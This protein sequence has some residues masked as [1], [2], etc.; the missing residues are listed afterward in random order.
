MAPN[1]SMKSKKSNWVRVRVLAKTLAIY[2]M[3]LCIILFAEHSQEV[4]R[5]RNCCPDIS[6][7]Y[8]IADVIS[9]Y[10]LLTVLFTISVAL[11]CGD[12]MGRAYLVIPFMAL[13]VMDFIL[14]ALVLCAI[15][16]ELP[17]YLRNTQ[18]GKSGIQDLES[19]SRI[20]INMVISLLTLCSSYAEVP[21]YL[22]IK[23]MNHL[24][25][26]LDDNLASKHHTMDL[27]TFTFLHISVIILKASMFYN[28]W[29]EFKI[30]RHM[31]QVVS[32]E[33]P[34]LKTIP[35]VAL[36]SYEEAIK[37]PRSD[38]PPPYSTI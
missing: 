13:Q 37:M 27:I 8:N 24:N 20:A 26:F 16:I 17:T 25:Y 6:K 12:L 4:S 22:N 23:T 35:K 38:F 33:T 2:H 10:L 18:Q 3:I 28:I 5:R 14:S 31:K 34:Q 15:Y 9:S 11:L 1:A 7:L 21:A 29:K 36:P 30:L 19:P 32:D